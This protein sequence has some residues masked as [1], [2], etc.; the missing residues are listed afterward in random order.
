MPISGPTV[1][2]RAS[3]SLITTS[4]VLCRHLVVFH[5]F[6]RNFSESIALSFQAHLRNAQFPHADSPGLDSLFSVGCRSMK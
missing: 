1:M 2:L 3:A 6:P 5:G 4:S